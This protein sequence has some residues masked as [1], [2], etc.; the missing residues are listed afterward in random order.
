LE[1]WREMARQVVHEIKNPLTP[2]QL[3]AERIRK[4]YIENHPDIKN[5]I[6]AGTETIVEE[7][8][9]LKNILHEFTE[10]ARLPEMKPVK[11]D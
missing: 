6:M 8:G 9:V 3:S 1:A 5:I 7:V 10:F 4:R 11:T 2:I